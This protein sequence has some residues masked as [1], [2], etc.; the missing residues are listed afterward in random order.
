MKDWSLLIAFHWPH[1]RFVFGWEII[2]PD[3]EFNT[4][5]FTLYLLIVTLTLEI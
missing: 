5:N 2:H 3:K 1:D 4:Y